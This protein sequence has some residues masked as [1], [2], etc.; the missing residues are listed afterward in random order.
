MPCKK[1][2]K[3][4]LA[5][6]VGLGLD[7]D[8]VIHGTV[9]RCSYPAQQKVFEE[10]NVPRYLWP[11][12][13]ETLVQYNGNPHAIFKFFGSFADAETC[14]R[15]YWKW[16]NHYGPESLPPVRGTRELLELL[17]AEGKHSFL[18]SHHPQRETE[19]WLKNYGLRRHLNFVWGGRSDRFGLA[20]EKSHILKTYLKKLDVDPELVPYAGDMPTDQQ[21]AFEAGMPFILVDIHFRDRSLLFP[22]PPDMYVRGP[23]EIVEALTSAWRGKKNT[24]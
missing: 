11:T 12:L 7:K 21:A 10:T 6:S 16:L 14:R 4:W 20:V 8:G 23:H 2:P 1:A 13:E 15:I 22:R 17:E 19:E 5:D 24:K 18:V 3:L 9:D